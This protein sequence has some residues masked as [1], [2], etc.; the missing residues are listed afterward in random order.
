M[1]QTLEKLYLLMRFLFLECS[2]LPGSCLSTTK[3]I[4]VKYIEETDMIVEFK[5]RFNHMLK[6]SN[7][8][9]RVIVLGKEVIMMIL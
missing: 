3:L 7:D 9:R 5:E 4:F 2:E 8:Y 6:K 1:K